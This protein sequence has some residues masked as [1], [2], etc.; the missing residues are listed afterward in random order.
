MSG[1]RRAGLDRESGLDPVLNA[2]AVLP[3][4]AIAELRERVLE[5]AEN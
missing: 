2:F 3:D 4:L 5:T 1:G